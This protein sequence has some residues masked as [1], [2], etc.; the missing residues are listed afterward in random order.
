MLQPQPDHELRPRLPVGGVAAEDECGRGE[1]GQ[2]L[3]PRPL[4]AR[5]PSGLQDRA[6]NR[7]FAEKA[8]MS[9]LPC[10]KL[11]LANFLF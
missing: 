1:A 3:Q 2:H 9:T 4:P 6:V 5:L 7:T 10:R 8:L 11:L